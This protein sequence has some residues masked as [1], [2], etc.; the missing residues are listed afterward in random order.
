MCNKL[1][2]KGKNTLGPLIPKHL[3]IHFLFK[4]WKSNPKQCFKPGNENA[5]TRRWERRAQCCPN[6]QAADGFR[7][8]LLKQAGSDSGSR[9]GWPADSLVPW[10][11]QPCLFCCGMRKGKVRG[12]PWQKVERGRLIS[13]KVQHDGWWHPALLFEDFRFLF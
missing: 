1:E 5:A 3:Q 8:R 12:K 4:G 13:E 6:W 11:R 10:I 7:L 2:S 9:R